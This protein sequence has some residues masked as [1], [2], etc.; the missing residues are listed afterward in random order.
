MIEKV[1]KCAHCSKRVTQPTSAIKRALRIG[2][3]LYCDRV[4]AGLGRRTFK[5]KA[6]KVSEKR[7]YD[8]EYRRKN[9]KAL[10]AK[11][12]AYFERVYDPVKAAAVRKTRMHLHVAYCQDPAYRRWKRGYDREYRA[13]KLYG[14]FAESF[15]L[16]QKIEREVST[17]MTRY[18]VYQA[19]GTLNK[20]LR[21]KRDYARL[22]GNEFKNGPVGNPAGHQERQNA[23]RA[24]RRDCRSGA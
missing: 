24:G 8:M 18:E 17:R 21:R 6:Q 5:T 2:A 19:N 23:S 12:R 11:K 20:T 13:Q 14:P 7:M 3:K 10:K 4:C 22:V 9:R 16:L 1:I 15:L